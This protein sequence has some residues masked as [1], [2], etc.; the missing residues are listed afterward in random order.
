VKEQA[1]GIGEQEALTAL[2]RWTLLPKSPLKR[3]RRKRRAL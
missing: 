2:G 3:A 1:K